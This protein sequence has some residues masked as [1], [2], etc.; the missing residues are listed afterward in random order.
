MP[1]LYAAAICTTIVNDGGPGWLYLLVLLFVWNAFELLWIRPVTLLL[2]V[3]RTAR[4]RRTH[5]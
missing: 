3:G 4:S 5:A 1:Y 2:M